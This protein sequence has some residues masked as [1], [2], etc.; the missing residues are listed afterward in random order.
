M[1][2]ISFSLRGCLRDA[3]VAQWVKALVAKSDNL[4]LIPE[5]HVVGEEGL[6]QTVL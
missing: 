1:Q 2:M 5:T 6:L 4:S 3:E